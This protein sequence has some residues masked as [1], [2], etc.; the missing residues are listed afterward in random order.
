MRTAV[1]YSCKGGSGRTLTLA[2]VAALLVRLGHD[3]LVLD[4]DLEAPGVPE[5]F[6]LQGAVLDKDGLVEHARKWLTA[7]PAADPPKL[8]IIEIDHELSAAPRA[9]LRLIQAGNYHDPEKY[10]QYASLMSEGLLES[11]YPL[12]GSRSASPGDPDEIEYIENYT[13]FWNDLRDQIAADPPDYLFVDS[14]TGFSPLSATTVDAFLS[15]E[16][17][18][19][20]GSEADLL[21]FADQGSEASRVGT[22]TFIR[23]IAKRLAGSSIRRR[24]SIV[25]REQSLAQPVVVRPEQS[26]EQ[27]IEPDE[28]QTTQE[29]L[30]HDVRIVDWASTIDHYLQITSDPKVEHSGKPLASLEGELVHRALLDDYVRVAAVLL[31]D[32]DG[33]AP[34]SD[35]ERRLEQQLGLDGRAAAYKLFELPG[36]GGM[37]NVADDKANVAFTEPT[38]HSLVT[39]LKYQDAGDESLYRAGVRAGNDF[40]ATFKRTA[41]SDVTKELVHHWQTL[42]SASGWGLFELIP[43]EVQ[44]FLESVSPEIKV[45]RNAFAPPPARETEELPIDAPRDDFAVD[46][47]RDN[48]LC[49]FLGGYLCGI[50]SSLTGEKFDYDPGAHDFCR[51]KGFEWCE[52]RFGRSGQYSS[53]ATVS[54]LPRICLVY[55]G[56]TIGMRRYSNGDLRPPEKEDDFLRV[57]PELREIVNYKFQPLLNKDSTNVVPSDWSQIAQYIYDHRNDGYKGFVVVHGT[58]TMHFSAAAVALAL[59]DGLP[60]PVVFTGAQTIPEVRHGDARVNLL[61][62]CEVATEDIAEVVISFGDY[63]F[64]G[65][66]AQKKDERRFDAFESPAIAPLGE[67]AEEIRLSPAVYTREQREQNEFVLRNKFE[68]G[69]LQVSLIPGLEPSLLLDV[70]KSDRLKGL[71]LQSFGAGNVPDEAAA[72]YSVIPMIELAKEHDKPVIVTS[73]FPA[74]AAQGEYA[75]GRRARKAGAIATG[76]MTASCSAA[77]F[78][79]ALAL[80]EI[81]ALEASPDERLRAIR[82]VMSKSYVGELDQMPDAETNEEGSA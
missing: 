52:F 31:H 15:D 25:R 49:A 39:H 20:E 65:A 53:V 59:G 41:P 3:V 19:Q 70:V 68:S 32:A 42:E 38:F 35:T 7:R 26:L 34:L 81:R 23:Q 36:T 27:P 45:L 55:T 33:P 6:G 1:F 47:R 50:L 4:L 28:T 24:T 72:E 30:T 77:K 5:A 75:P 44:D 69:V 16:L 12:P 79:W 73:Q 21:V 67:I 76:N 71:I 2:N 57:A 10:D 54:S 9:R 82:R 14:R 17:A 80:P 48:N 46:M 37:F 61:R 64:R 63:I 18:G 51:S 62:A 11:L 29:W 78:R 74:N 13:A 60:F 43:G 22:R 40:G 56:G 58:D 66:R 8:P